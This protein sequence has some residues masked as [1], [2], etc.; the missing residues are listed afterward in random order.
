MF[1]KLSLKAKEKVGKE[2]GYSEEVKTE[3]STG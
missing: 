1:R 2:T 3:F